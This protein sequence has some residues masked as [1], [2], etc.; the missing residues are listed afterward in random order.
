MK[1]L[2][3]LFLLF[4]FIHS[5]VGQ[6]YNTDS[7]ITKTGFTKNT[8]GNKKDTLIFLSSIS[9]NKKP[10]P[11]IIF[12]QGS[13]PLPLVFFDSVKP[14][15][16]LPFKIDSFVDKFNIILI[17]RRGIPLVTTFE[18]GANGYYVNNGEPPLQYI[19]NDNL[20]SRVNDLRLV[21][22]F[23]SKKDWVKKDSIFMIGH[24]EGYRVSAKYCSTSK[25]IK[26]VACLSGNPFSR[27]RDKELNLR[28]E[29]MV[30][31]SD[32]VLDSINQR[33]I[34]GIEYNFKKRFYGDNF[35]NRE[36]QFDLNVLKLNNENSY[37]KDLPYKNL[38]KVKIPI[39]V[40]YGS[41]DVSSLDNDL[42]PF[43]FA[44]ENK[45]NLTMYP[46]A[47]VEHNFMKYTLNESGEIIKTDFLWDQVWRDVVNWFLETDIF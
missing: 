35:K 39:L 26:K 45:K 38:L 17:S 10:K 19:I 13:L 41:K 8:L 21:V 43:I 46:Y 32:L 16:L 28:K 18:E 44:G 31:D 12:V 2:S 24:S 6:T 4:L 11:T 29:S 7:L 37:M 34:N 25:K 3:F 1:Y 15:T 33:K 23:L 22:D 20:E 36:N 40:A 27:Q 5:I 9:K 30:S 47:G 42:L 14:F